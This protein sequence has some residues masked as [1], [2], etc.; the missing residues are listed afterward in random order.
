MTEKEKIEKEIKKIQ[1][2]LIMANKNDGWW[3]EHMKSMLNYY[4]NKLK[5]YE[6]VNNRILNKEN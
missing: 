4:E 2:E 3:N 6:D 5:K 1:L